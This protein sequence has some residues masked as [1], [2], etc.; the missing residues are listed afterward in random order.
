MSALLQSVPDH[1]PT[2]GSGSLTV[3]TSCPGVPG[4]PPAET[5]SVLDGVN[6]LHE[7]L[8][9]IDRTQTGTTNEFAGL[10][11]ELTR[12]TARI[13]S[14]R[15]A[16]VADADKAQVA[17]F[18]GA[19]GT[20]AW[21]AAQT[22]TDE[23][24]AV[25]DSKLATQL[26]DGQAPATHQALADGKVSKEHA[27]VILKAITDLPPD[28]TQSERDKAERVLL[29]RAEHTS[30]GKLRREAR[31]VVEEAGRS[32]READ[33][34]QGELLQSEEEKAL[35]RCRFTLHDNNDGTASGAFT[36]PTLA[37][38]ILRKTLQQ[39]TAPRRNNKSNAA[40]STRGVGALDVA[41]GS[42]R[43]AADAHGV[44]ARSS[45]GAAGS[46]GFDTDWAHRQGLA[47][48]DL[49]EHLPTDRLSGKV[50]ATVV[51][52]VEHDHLRDQ[53]G[54]AK[55]DTGHDVSAA[56]ARRIACGAGIL[57]LVLG[58]QSQIL[59]LGRSS[60]YFTEAQRT[61]LATRYDEC[62]AEGCDRPYAWTE[63]HHE[64]PWHSSGRTDLELAVP[65]CGFH[66]R[67]MH[68]PKYI[69]KITT[70]SGKKTV[71][72]TRRT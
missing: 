26:G 52:T 50:A 70:V 67:R 41:A 55:L 64:D 15:M 62:A 51:V 7:V 20:G 71:T 61:A 10:V 32:K 57:P 68:D 35:A 40:G 44:A 8:D 2:A 31:R 46:P 16:V 11:R 25:A 24:V 27:A 12:A 66:H 1:V 28:L 36:V 54:A 22:R 39:M 4:P 3:G 53:I 59:D 14:L 47:F 6:R 48:A 37:A 58:G 60:R 19:C 33:K 42:T 13:E 49:L 30:P 29:R 34:H 63:L 65:L 43:G 72:Y 9:R 17:G 45:R 5:L 56:E 21:L 69:T 38:D 23:R 18:S